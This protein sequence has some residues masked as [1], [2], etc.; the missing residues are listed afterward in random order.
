MITYAESRGTIVRDDHDNILEYKPKDESLIT[1]VVIDHVGLI[2]YKDYGSKK[3][4]IDMTSRHL[5]FFRNMCGFSPI[6]V[7]QINRGSEH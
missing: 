2:N 4:A 5:V 1:L 3:E 6:P 7:S